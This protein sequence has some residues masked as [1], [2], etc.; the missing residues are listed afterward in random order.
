M[1]HGIHH[2]TLRSELH[3]YAELVSED[4]REYDTMILMAAAHILRDPSKRTPPPT[5][6][7]PNHEKRPRRGPRRRSP[8][9]TAI[10]G[11]RLPDHKAAVAFSARRLHPNGALWRRFSRLCGNSTTKAAERAREPF[12]AE[13]GRAGNIIESITT[14]TATRRQEGQHG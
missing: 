14:T 3:R 6:F 4:G 2:A 1:T 10:R 13:T 12:P 11:K 9:R 5:Q 7:L 8:D